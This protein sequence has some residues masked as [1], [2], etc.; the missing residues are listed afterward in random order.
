MLGLSSG[1]TILSPAGLEWLSARIGP[2]RMEQLM[3][4]LK[5]VRSSPSLSLG[6]FS[7]TATS[8]P[9]QQLPSKRL[10]TIYVNGE[11]RRRLKHEKSGLIKVKRFSR[12]Y[13]H[14]SPLFKDP[15]L[16]AILNNITQIHHPHLRGMLCL[17][18]LY[19]LGIH[20]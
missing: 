9:R 6:H 16:I 14:G 20:Q 10:A 5:F 4:I 11:L 13:S 8:Q 12:I 15:P 17:M 1:L 7:G 19:V 2:S 18:L 3:K